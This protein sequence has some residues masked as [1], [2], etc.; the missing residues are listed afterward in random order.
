MERTK[1]RAYLG[2]PNIFSPPDSSLKG[3]LFKKIPKPR[4]HTQAKPH[5]SLSIRI[6]F[7]KRGLSLWGLVVCVVGV[8]GGKVCDCGRG[9]G[10][11]GSHLWSTQ[12]FWEGAYIFQRPFSLP[13]SYPE[14]IFFLALSIPAASTTSFNLNYIIKCCQ[15]IECD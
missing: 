10:R 14:C 1:R 4:K 6:P 7:L 12:T 2:L 3:W 15:G 5:L 9:Q 8:E 11:K 13:P